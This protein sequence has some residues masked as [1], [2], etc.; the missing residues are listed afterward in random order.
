[1]K[2]LNV[3]K[4]TTF[5]VET[6]NP[7]FGGRYRRGENGGW[8]LQM[9]ESWESVYFDE[10]ELEAAFREFLNGRTLT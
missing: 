1:M 10:D 8:E 4:S 7:E 2:I 3:E 9:G 6:D 5:Y